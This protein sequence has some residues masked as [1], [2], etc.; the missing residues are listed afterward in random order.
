M[1]VES[2]PK[3]IILGLN[4]YEF[5][6]SFNKKYCNGEG[7]VEK[8]IDEGLYTLSDSKNILIGIKIQDTF[9]TIYNPRNN[10]SL[11]I[12]TDFVSKMEN[13]HLFLQT[14]LQNKANYY[15]ACK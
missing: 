1:N 15:L 7:V 14:A 9:L 10:E 5:L 13:S 3:L 4:P 6:E 2:Y 8:K 12:D 11:K